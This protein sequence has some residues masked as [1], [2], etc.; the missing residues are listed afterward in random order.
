[1]CKECLE[2]IP[3]KLCSTN[4][5]QPWCSST[6]KRL[7]CKKQHQYNRARLSNN[8]NDWSTYYSTKKLV[9]QECRKAYNKYVSDLV[10][11]KG[12]ISK[13]LW[14]Y[15]KSKR[16]NQIGVPSLIHEGNIYS[17][18]LTKSNILNNYVLQKKT[19]PQYLL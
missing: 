18:S 2:H 10:D 13:R 11:E 5:K 8:P 15:I 17:D 14:S 3:T 4:S 19:Q 6:I 1:M 7:C 12:N 9:Q 16:T